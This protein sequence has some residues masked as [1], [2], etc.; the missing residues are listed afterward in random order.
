MTTEDARE[1][2]VS[3]EHR[4]QGGRESS[5]ED[6]PRIQ[7]RNEPVSCQALLGP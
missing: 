4:G 6:Q 5:K 7:T 3:V 2:T 1:A